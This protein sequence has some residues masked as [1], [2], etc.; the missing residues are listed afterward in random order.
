MFIEMNVESAVEFESFLSLP[1]PRRFVT[2][3]RLDRTLPCSR[4]DSPTAE[5]RCTLRGCE[6]AGRQDSRVCESTSDLR[7]AHFCRLTEF[8]NRAENSR[9]VPPL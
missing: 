4:T 1:P 9:L 8:R 2:N 7:F 6:L 3:I 5:R